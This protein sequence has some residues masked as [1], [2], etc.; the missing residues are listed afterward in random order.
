[1]LHCRHYS[2]EEG[3]L[4]FWMR[5]RVVGN[6]AQELEIDKKNGLWVLPTK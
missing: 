3:V 5:R 2:S 1:V 6:T 4:I